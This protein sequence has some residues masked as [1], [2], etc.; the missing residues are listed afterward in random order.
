MVDTST[1]ST[2]G[3]V[4][5][6]QLANLA[7]DLNMFSTFFWSDTVYYDWCLPI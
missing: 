1:V 7:L 4:E 3:P 2:V 6:I 5:M